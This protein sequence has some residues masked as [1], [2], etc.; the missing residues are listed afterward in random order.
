VA[1]VDTCAKRDA[2]EKFYSKAQAD[3]CARKG[4]KKTG[5]LIAGLRISLG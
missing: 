2:L 1:Q 4:N 5:Y 3:A